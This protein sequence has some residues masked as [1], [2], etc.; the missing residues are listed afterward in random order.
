M[1]GVRGFMPAARGRCECSFK[2]SPELRG[3]VELGEEVH[4]R[5][6]TY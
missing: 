3:G 1:K 2:S 6:G 5:A 4:E